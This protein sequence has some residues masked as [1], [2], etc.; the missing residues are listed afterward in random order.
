[1]FRVSDAETGAL[2]F[3]GSADQVADLLDAPK[4]WITDGA[5]LSTEGSQVPFLVRKVLPRVLV[6]SPYAG[7]VAE[8]LRYLRACL[9]DSLDRGEAP[10][11]SHLF[12]TQILD[13]TVPEERDLG[14][15]AGFAWGECADFVA[16]YQDRGL[17]PGMLEGLK[18]HARSGVRVDFRTLGHQ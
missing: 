18:A 11:A 17:S 1:M 5:R 8:N 16:V 9:K 3:R 7:D 12:Y 15:R 13:D 4:D 14:M 10:F 2:V 6:E